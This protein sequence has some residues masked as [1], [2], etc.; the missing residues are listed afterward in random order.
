MGYR[1][2]MQGTYA[3]NRTP[4]CSLQNIDIAKCLHL[5][6]V[7]SADSAQIH[8]EWKNLWHGTSRIYS[9]YSLM[10]TVT[11]AAWLMALPVC[12][13]SVWGATPITPRCNHQQ[14]PLCPHDMACIHKA[15]PSHRAHTQFPRTGDISTG[16]S[17]L[18]FCKDNLHIQDVWLA[19][20]GSCSRMSC[21]CT[22]K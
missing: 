14:S 20:Q 13:S 1:H 6:M 7:P 17:G 19:T 16:H 12:N 5:V 2:W 9:R 11:H 8:Q 15:S 21:S 10:T 4:P 18:P 22:V 3:S